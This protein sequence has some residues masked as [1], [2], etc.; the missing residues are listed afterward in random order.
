MVVLDDLFS[1][2]CCPWSLYIRSMLFSSPRVHSDVRGHSRT[3]PYSV[4]L[5]DR[6]RNYTMSSGKASSLV[7]RTEVAAIIIV[8]TP[9]IARTI[10]MCLFGEHMVGQQGRSL[11][12]LP[13]R[14]NDAGFEHLVPTSRTARVPRGVALF[15][16]GGYQKHPVCA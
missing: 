10:R 1:L 9:V 2:Q 11:G 4:G 8:A 12:L 13:H 16:C 14:V 7:C 3:A 6:S 15:Q 5:E